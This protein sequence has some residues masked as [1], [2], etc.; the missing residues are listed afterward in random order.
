MSH[1]HAFDRHYDVI[2][3]GARPAGAATAMLLARR[4][5][6]VLAIDRQRLGS[7]TL[8]TH[9]LMRGAV[10][11][12][13][14]WG[15]LDRIVRA[16][17]PAIRQTSFH[18]GD[19]VIAIDIKPDGGVDRLYAPRRTVLD[20]VLAEGARASGAQLRHGAALTELV[21][22]SDGR[23]VGAAIR[24]EEGAMHRVSADLLIGADGRHSTVARLVGAHTYRR[25]DYSTATIYGYFSGLENQ[26]YRW[27]YSPG[28]SAGAIPTNNGE[29]C[30]FVSLPPD[31]FAREISNGSQALFDKVL[32]ETSP[33]FAEEVSGAILAGHLHGFPGEAGYFRQSFGAGWALVG[34]AGYF[35]D[36]LTA[37]GITD[38]LRDAELLALAIADG[39]PEAYRHYQSERDALSID[40]FEATDAIASF[41]WDIDT[42][43]SHNLRLSKAMKAET[44]ALVA[45]DEPIALAA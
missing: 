13:S 29:T 2:V 26:G 43:K 31:R 7:D 9:A 34:D 6:E 11:Q 24:D 37:H 14:R 36:P 39:R 28:V 18:Y 41:E 35:K 1:A 44:A 4:G 32:A 5:L 21:R 10:I 42:L 20:Q 25:S 15:L 23:V 30:V 12:L 8:S 45:R 3:V 40:L 17:T 19:D 33:E 38:G 22:T 16:D 27:F